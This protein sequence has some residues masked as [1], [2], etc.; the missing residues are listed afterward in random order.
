[1]KRSLITI[2][3]FCFSYVTFGQECNF[4]DTK[5][6]IR[7]IKLGTSII[8]YPEFQ[9]REESNAALFK[10]S[11]NAKTNYVYVGSENDQLSGAKILFIY[12]IVDD[13]KIS[14][15]KIVTQKVMSVYSTLKLAYGEPT[16]KYNDKLIWRTNR[17][18]CSIEGDW[19]Q[20]PGYHITYKAVS[21][22][23]KEL[24]NHR[25]KLAKEAQDEL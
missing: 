11:M 22:A 17:I 4:L 6:G 12:L 10:L 20:V 19:S 8:D 23:R 21:D 7:N 24:N 15:I 16:Q 5:N 18:E 9:K 13:S 25:E 3:I 2:F 1:M 14:E